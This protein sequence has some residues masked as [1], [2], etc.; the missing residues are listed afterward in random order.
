MAEEKKP[1]AAKAPKAEGEAKKAGKAKARLRSLLHGG[2]ARG[3]PPGQVAARGPY[4]A[5]LKK[6][7]D[8]VVRAKLME[9]FGY[10][11]AFEVPAIEKIV[12]N[13]GVGE[14]VNDT[15][16]VTRRLPISA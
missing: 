13:M 9:Q 11:N 7:Y 5:R 16:K 4:T 8:E 6:H 2:A 3:A 15:K 14:A 1:K 12:L 10:K